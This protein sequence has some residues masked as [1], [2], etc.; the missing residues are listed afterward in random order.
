MIH[1]NKVGLMFNSSMET[2][3]RLFSKAGKN[4]SKH[5]WKSN[6]RNWAAPKIT[7]NWL[8]EHLTNP[9]IDM[10]NYNSKPE[11]IAQILTPSLKLKLP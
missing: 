10:T 6:Q 11:I 8:K 2:R 4:S 3:F 9:K 5:N 1:G 7:K